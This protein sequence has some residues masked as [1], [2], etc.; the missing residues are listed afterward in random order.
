[1]ISIETAEKY[2][3]EHLLGEFFLESGSALSLAALR[4]AENDVRTRL[5]I[6]PDGQDADYIAAVC[7]QA[8]FLLM[9]KDHLISEAK[10]VVSETIEGLGSF[11]YAGNEKIFA[12]RTEIFIESINRRNRSSA[13]SINIRRG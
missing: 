8:V 2:F 6:L 3:N 9:H 5:D 1:M 7:E 4:M 11:T 10:N 12:P 13:S